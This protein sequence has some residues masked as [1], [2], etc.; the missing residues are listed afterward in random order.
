MT[1]EEQNNLISYIK[2][3]K[4]L[5]KE[6]GIIGIILP[7][8]ITTNLIFLVS[9]QKIWAIINLIFLTISTITLYVICKNQAQLSG[10]II[11]LL[12][13]YKVITIHEKIITLYNKE[14]IIDAAKNNRSLDLRTNIHGNYTSAIKVL[15]HYPDLKSIKK[16]ENTYTI[17][18]LILDYQQDIVTI[19]KKNILK[20]YI[21]YKT[22]EPIGKAELKHKED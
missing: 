5:D 8:F 11:L 13:D 6:I 16:I 21:E 4:K 3:Y 14:D 19:C 12:K 1:T 18:E 7:I 20:Q 10:S 2:K 9:N 15:K 17:N 22:T